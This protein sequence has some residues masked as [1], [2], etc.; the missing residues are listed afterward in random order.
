MHD[1]LTVIHTQN[2]VQNVKYLSPNAIV[3]GMI[4]Y[5]YNVFYTIGGIIDD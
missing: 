5:D 1:M 4:Y 3:S 2:K